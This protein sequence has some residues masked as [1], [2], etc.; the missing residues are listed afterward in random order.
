MLDPG[1]FPDDNGDQHYE[2]EEDE[3]LEFAGS[4]DLSYFESSHMQCLRRH[5]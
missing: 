3:Y 2:D 1:E 5:Y 4:S